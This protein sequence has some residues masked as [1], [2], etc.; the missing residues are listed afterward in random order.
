MRLVGGGGG[1]GGEGGEGGREYLVKY[2]GLAHVHCAWLAEAAAARLNARKLKNA[3]EGRGSGG[4]PWST[5]D[6]RNWSPQRVCARRPSPLAG[7][8]FQYL[9]KWDGDGTGLGYDLATWEGQKGV[10]EQHT[11]LIDALALRDAAARARASPQH[12]ALAE[13]A[14]APQHASLLRAQPP[15]LPGGPPPPDGV[16]LPTL[17]PHQVEALNFLRASYHA[18][19]SVILAD[20]MVR[21]RAVPCRNSA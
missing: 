9:V 16:A 6:Q 7:E 17:M 19:H 5:V 12:R 1:E 3:A 11:H 21:A 4:E 10:L 14:R 20:E 13:A 15:W 8:H 2:E 18:D